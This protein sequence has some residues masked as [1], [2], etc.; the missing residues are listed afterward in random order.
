MVW[1]L[2]L[3]LLALPAVYAQSTGATFGEVVRL[4]G[5]PSDLVLDQSRGRLYLVNPN[6]NRVDVYS[7]L[8]K[9]LTSSIG[10]GNSPVAAALS[11]DNNFLY[12]SNAQSASLSVI[13]L[14]SGS[15]V[16]TVSLAANPE[17]V[18]V[19][20]DGRVLITTQG[21][22]STDQVNSLLIF[23]PSQQQAQKVQSVQFPPPPPTPSPL[24]GV[25]LTRPITQFRGKLLRTPD[26]SF[27]VGL[28][29]INNNQ[30]TVLFVYETAS[31]SILRSRTVTGQSTVLSMAPDGS[32]FMAGFTL[33]D[34]ATL[35]VIAQ[36]NAANL[37]F[38]LSS[39]GTASFNTL[40]NVG[41]SVFSPD[42]E[43]LYSAFNSAPFSQPATRPQASTL[44]ISSSRHLGARLGI[45]IPESLI[46]KM[47]I[48]SDGAEA[49]GLSESGLLHLPLATL[50]DYPILQPET[51]TV[52]LAVDNC[53]RGLA[54]GT[55]RVN[56]LGKGKLTFSVPNTTAALVAYLTTG[57]APTTITFLMEPGRTGVTRQPGTNLYTGG[58]S[59]SG[60]ALTLDLASPEAI[61]IPNTIKVYMNYRQNDQRG[62]IYPVTTV[63]TTSE[64][65]QDILV[66]EARNRVYL[67]NSGYNRLEVFDTVKQRFLAPIEVGQ[68]PHQMAMGTDGATLYVAH[69]GGES[70]S[71][72][73]LDLGKVIN[74]VEF[75]PIPRS[76]SANPVTPQTLAMGLSGLQF[77]KSDGSQWKV[78]NNQASVRPANSV[79]PTQISATS[80]QGPPRMIAAPGGRSIITLGGNGTAYLYDA[81]ADTYTVSSLLYTQQPIQSYFGPLG[82]GPE[83]SYFLV[84]GLVLNSSLA[85]LG[86]SENPS[87]T[88]SAPLAS[89]RHVAAVY[90]IDENTF[91]R[92]TVQARQNVSSTGSGDSRPTLEL[93]DLRNY[94][95]SS[96]GAVAENPVTSVFGASRANVPPRQLVLDSSGTAY[97][98][99][100]SGLSVI[101]LSPA[102]S[103]RPQIADGRS[104]IVNATDGSPT[105]RPGAFL[106]V[107]GTNLAS[108]AIAERIPAPTLLGGSCV[109]F[110]DVPIPLLQTSPSQIMA[111]LPDTLQPG[112]Y[113]VQV[114]SLA[115]AQ[116]S[117]PM[118][119]TVQ[120]P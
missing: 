105:Y 75:P 91:L 10:V 104:G 120:R 43:T 86:G 56:N 30:S 7:Y 113:V 12:V 41:G 110:S 118:V 115:L 40:Q 96:A 26:G 70:I 11:M 62:V 27:I 111:Q 66:D 33:Y 36:Q 29:T 76:G 106:L 114:R 71:L 63:P 116:Q 37:P 99:T 23:D 107:N 54:W 82:A 58:A 72:V 16:E 45:K 65:L 32:R 74:S 8:E 103:G 60:A 73:D 84:N 87:S 92:F 52:F 15:V 42:G 21:T 3:A 17:G 51:T 93:V 22:S 55:L 9:R 28:S 89:R 109:T 1:L 2:L 20:W 34:T 112:T 83:G 67:A 18:E 101:P 97:A 64:G 14:S 119:V 102:G 46:A 59:N 44:L 49:W 47:V 100:L 5:T 24:P 98:I 6:A 13:D 53:N 69:T 95:V 31:G 68:L 79:T 94:S 50:Y 35:A 57:V 90:G 39:S 88:T 61:N 85:I 117:D 77:I 48:T 81:L 4:S 108:K 25:T 80:A 19:G 78:V 38:P